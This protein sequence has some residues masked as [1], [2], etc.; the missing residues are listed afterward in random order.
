MR[1]DDL[2]RMRHMLDAAVILM[3]YSLLFA[4]CSGS[5]EKQVAHFMQISQAKNRD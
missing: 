4:P 3:C 1:K 5:F 2:I